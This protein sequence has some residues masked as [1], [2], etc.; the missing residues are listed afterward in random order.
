[1]YV[2]FWNTF[3]T[4]VK[5][6]FIYARMSISNI[7]SWSSCLPSWIHQ[8]LQSPLLTGVRITSWLDVAILTNSLSFCNTSSKVCYQR[9]VNGHLYAKIGKMHCVVLHTRTNNYGKA[10]TAKKCYDLCALGDL[11]PKAR[12]PLLLVKLLLNKLLRGRSRGKNT[13]MPNM[14]YTA[15]LTLGHWIIIVTPLY[16]P[17]CKL[18]FICKC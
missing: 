6:Q 10:R 1:M 5:A 11:D 14:I 17:I 15:S 12:L 8:H 4:S 3:W 18:N 2:S 7:I 16:L 13:D 9:V